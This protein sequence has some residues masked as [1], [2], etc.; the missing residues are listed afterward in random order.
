MISGFD[1]RCIV[2]ELAD[3][4]VDAPVDEEKGI[5]KKLSKYRKRQQNIDDGSADI[6]VE[7]R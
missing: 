7:N 6:S 2:R 5:S 1:C 4:V 3:G